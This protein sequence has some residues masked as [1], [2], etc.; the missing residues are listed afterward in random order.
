MQGHLLYHFPRG[1]WAA[2]NATYYAGGRTRVNGVEGDDLQRN[3]RMGATLALPVTL[4]HSVKLYASTGAYSR[5]GGDFDLIGIA[6]Q[7][8]WGGGL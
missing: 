5:A 2:L 1:I 3:W 6:W 4:R 8:R 7:Y